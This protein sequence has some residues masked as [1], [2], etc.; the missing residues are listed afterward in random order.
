MPASEFRSP[1][2]ELLVELNSLWQQAQ[3]R[4]AQAGSRLTLARTSRATGVP[5][6]TLSD[7]LRGGHLPRDAT[8]LLK[9]VTE[10]CTWA[11]QAPPSPAHWR[12]LLDAAGHNP[13]RAAPTVPPAAHGSAIAAL[14]ELLTAAFAEDD[15][16]IDAV[17]LSGQALSIAMARPIHA[18][19]TGT[20]R[21][22]SVTVRVLLPSRDIDLAFPSPVTYDGDDTLHQR[23][24]AQ[25]NAYGQ[26]L[27]GALMSLRDTHDIETRI[28]F[29]ALPFTPMAKLYLVNHTEALFSYYT[30][31]RR[32]QDF[33]G[34]QIDLF[35]ANPMGLVRLFGT[36][37]TSD[38]T[39]FVAQSRQWFDS[40]WESVTTDLVLS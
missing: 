40:L 13:A 10:L 22:V 4:L 31:H 20:V 14:G 7:W 39:A 26:T 9:V 6:A 27:R 12:R 38:D 19:H 18:V 33:E 2:P 25:R 15:V 29:R 30:I 37:S 32:T 17:C 34:R 11:A 24:L 16:A 1:P 21:P 3:T 23:W 5:V 8:D 28:T 35:D 36:D